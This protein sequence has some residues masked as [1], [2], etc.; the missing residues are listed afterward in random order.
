[1]LHAIMIQAMLQAIGW[2]KI[3]LYF[4]R[5]KVSK[6]RKCPDRCVAGMYTMITGNVHNDM[7][8]TK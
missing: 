3:Y 7:E 5:A 8:R 1:M 4:L 2:I 6:E